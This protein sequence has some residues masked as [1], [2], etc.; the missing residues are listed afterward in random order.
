MTNPT[1]EERAARLLKAA[2]A[3]M[4]A[5]AALI[6]KLEAATEGNR[7]LDA[8]I[9][10]TTMGGE[11]KKSR[12]PTGY[13]SETVARKG[14]YFGVFYNSAETPPDKFDDAPRFTTSI[15]AALTLKRTHDIGWRGLSLKRTHDIG[16]RGL[17][18]SALVMLPKLHAPTVRLTQDMLACVICSIAL[19]AQEQKP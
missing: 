12:D 1:P 3:P 2:W 6:A 8:E 11:E 13:V 15:D 10:W 18:E 5:R 16:W 19:K 4:T 14:R 7:E 17:L 9:W